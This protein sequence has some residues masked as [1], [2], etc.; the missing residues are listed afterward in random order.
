MINETIQAHHFAERAADETAIAL[1]IRCDECGTLRNFVIDNTLRELLIGELHDARISTTCENCG[2]K[3]TVK[4]T[5]I[6]P[7]DGYS[8]RATPDEFT[9]SV[10]DNNGLALPNKPIAD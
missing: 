7:T 1:Q 3:I 8:Y 4:I 9:S 2:K 5:R 10:K 6:A